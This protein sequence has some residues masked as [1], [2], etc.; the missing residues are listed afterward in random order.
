M[1]DKPPPDFAWDEDRNFWN[2]LDGF[3]HLAW[4]PLK[5][6][7]DPLYEHRHEFG[8]HANA[9]L[10][11]GIGRFMQVYNG[12]RAKG[13]SEVESFNAAVSAVEA[14]VRVKRIIDGA[15]QQTVDAQV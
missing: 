12:S 11:G 10:F 4:T 7:L 15:A 3:T 13:M 8:P 9:I 1:S 5:E 2:A 6:L 14:D